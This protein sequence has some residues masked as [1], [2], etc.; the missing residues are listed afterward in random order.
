MKSG[1]EK[2]TNKSFVEALFKNV[3]IDFPSTAGECVGRTVEKDDTKKVRVVSSQNRTWLPILVL[4]LSLSLSLF[5]DT[6]EWGVKYF[7]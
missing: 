5:C 1:K 4:F 6:V 2:V 3:L 7:N